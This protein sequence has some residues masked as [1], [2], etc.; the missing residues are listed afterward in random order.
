MI[1]I[2][3]TRRRVDPAITELMA[4]G[5]R[6]LLIGAFPVYNFRIANINVPAQLRGLNELFIEQLMLS[7]AVV[8]Q[9]DPITLMEAPDFFTTRK[10][11][12]VAGQ[13]RLEAVRRLDHETIAARVLKPD[14]ALAALLQI[15]SNLRRLNLSPAETAWHLYLR[16]QLF[17]SVNGRAKAIGARAANKAMGHNANDKLSVAFSSTA[18]DLT[19]LST[20]DIQRAVKR[21]ETLGEELLRRVQG[22]CLDKATFLDTLMAAT[23]EDRE[24]IITDAEAGVKP[25][26]ARAAAQRT[27]S[28]PQVNTQ[29]ETE[30][31]RYGLTTNIERENFVVLKDA[32]AGACARSRAAFRDFI[33]RT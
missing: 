32:W 23:H 5:R 21:A 12:L 6:E 24:R 27:Q 3:Y 25:M 20:R 28:S 14:Q 18:A 26:S 22:T 19:G 31:E 15:E 10:A 4:N 8:G 2:E 11:T 13:H 17:E 30:M 33:D 16:K 29:V 9:I 7:I 1:E